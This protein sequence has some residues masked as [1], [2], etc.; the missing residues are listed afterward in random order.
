MPDRVADQDHARYRLAAAPCGPTFVFNDLL[1]HCRVCGWT[2][3]EHDPERYDREWERLFTI[4]EQYRIDSAHSGGFVR[5]FIRRLW[6]ESGQNP[7]G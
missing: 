2:V 1:P 7:A 6:P 3:R 5:R 4:P